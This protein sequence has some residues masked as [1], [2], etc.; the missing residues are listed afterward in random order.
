MSCPPRQWPSTGTPAA[1]ARADRAP[2]PSAIQGRS[3][4]TLIGPP[5][6]ARPGTRRR[7]RGNR[8]ARVDLHQP[9]GNPVR[10]EVCGKIAR[11]FGRAVAE[12]GDRLHSQGSSWTD[13]HSMHR[14]ARAYC[15]PALG[16][17][18]AAALPPT[19]TWSAC[20]P[21]KAVVLIDGGAPRTLSVGQKTA[22]GVTLL[23]VD[24][25]SGHVR[26]RRQAHDAGAWASSTRRAARPPAAHSVTL[27]ADSRGHFVADGQIN[28]GAMRF[29]VDTGATRR[30]RIPAAEAQ[31]AWGSTTA[32]ASAAMMK[33][34]NGTARPT[35]SS[36]IPC[37]SAT[38]TV[39][40]VD[41]VVMEG[42]SC[43]SPCSA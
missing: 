18:A 21:N 41:A 29:L 9:P 17:A 19:S 20:S 24:R 39:N 36:S 34:A 43:P 38:S 40:N 42:S 7:I 26:D 31:R 4:L 25:D 5:M 6:N 22:E 23:S 2:A 14:C 27:T 3:S 28:G 32:R 33:T 30:S 10:V 15:S 37:G 13:C 35:A 1:T 16:P 12:D 11:A 8:V